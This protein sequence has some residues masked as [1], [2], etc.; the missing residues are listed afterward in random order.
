MFK[1]QYR[2]TAQ[3]KLNHPITYTAEYFILKF[4]KNNLPYSRYGII[5]SK[6]IDKRAVKRN[7]IKRKLRSYLEAIQPRVKTGYDMLFIARPNIKEKTRTEIG[8]QIQESCSKG[9]LLN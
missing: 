1:R 5:V 7:Q 4:S 6:K 9:N 3:T 8:L 2:F